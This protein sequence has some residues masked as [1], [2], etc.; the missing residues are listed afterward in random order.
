MSVKPIKEQLERTKDIGESKL[1]PA[2]IRDIEES[3]PTKKLP[4]VR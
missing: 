1:T 2:Q 3:R 4:I